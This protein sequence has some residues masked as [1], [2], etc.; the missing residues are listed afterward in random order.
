MRAAAVTVAPPHARVVDAA[1][2]QSLARSTQPLTA[3][4]R[5]HQIRGTCAVERRRLQV[6]DDALEHGDRTA[7]LLEHSGHGSSPRD[8]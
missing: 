7:D 3:P 1:R 6:A 2:H 8:S 5:L 4:E